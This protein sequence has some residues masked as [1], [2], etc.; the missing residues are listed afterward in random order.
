MEERRVH[1]LDKR[2]GPQRVTA[3]PRLPEPRPPHRAP[4]EGTRAHGTG[5]RNR[6]TRR[7]TGPW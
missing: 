1:P 3:R 4:P 2:R 5:A 7:D 6:R